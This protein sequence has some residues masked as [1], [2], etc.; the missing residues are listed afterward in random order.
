MARNEKNL[1]RNKSQYS[2]NNNSEISGSRALSSS[3]QWDS[4]VVSYAGSLWNQ[5]SALLISA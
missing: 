2:T 5:E 1:V 3:S 4:S